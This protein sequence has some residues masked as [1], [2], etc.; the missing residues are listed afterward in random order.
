MSAPDERAAPDDLRAKTHAGY[1][2]SAAAAVWITV[3][4]ALQLVAIPWLL[5]DPEEMGL[6]AILQ[7]LSGFAIAFSDLGISGAIIQRSDNTPDKLSRLYQI[8]LGAAAVAAGAIAA[9]G[10]LLAQVYGQDRLIALAPWAAAPVVIAAVGNSFALLLQKDLEF[11][12]LA[13]TDAWAASLGF[14]AVVTGLLLDYGALALLWGPLV[15]SLVRSSVVVGVGWPRWPVRWVRGHVDVSSHL[16]FGIYQVGERLVNV[17]ASRLDQ[18]I[19]GSMFDT[20]VLGYY[21]LAQQYAMSPPARVNQS[22]NAVSLPVLARQIHQPEAARQT[23]LEVL[24]AVVHI[25]APLL[26]GLAVVAAPMV[27]VLAGDAWAP[28][29]PLVALYALIQLVRSH[30]NPVGSLLVAAGKASWGF[31]WNIGLLGLQSPLV[32]LAAKTGDYRAPA[33]VLLALQAAYAPANYL[34][35]VRPLIGGPASSYI[36]ATVLSAV[37]ALAMGLAVAALDRFVV[38]SWTP[39]PRLGATV[40]FGAAV[41][42]A[43]LALFVPGAV[44]HVAGWMRGSANGG[45]TRT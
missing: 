18:L 31:W 43:L 25:N 4:Q 15:Q 36:R 33:V 24:T 14:L 23:Y 45:P 22:F 5:G 42:A 34:L 21:A 10:P 6:F 32:W 26:I 16:R 13:R 27:Q 38:G 29:I 19:V 28:A 20:R 35:L 44:R 39:V 41:H 17:A 37:P 30:A 2:A 11:R 40:A 9:S 3:V 7:L 12:L 8:N 1:R